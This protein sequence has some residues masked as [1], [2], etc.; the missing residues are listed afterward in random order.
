MGPPIHVRRADPGGV[1][2]LQPGAL[3]AI[4]TLGSVRREEAREQAADHRTPPHAPGR[5]RLRSPAS[6]QRS[7]V[8]PSPPTLPR[9]RQ[10]TRGARSA[11]ERSADGSRFARRTCPSRHSAFRLSRPRAPPLS[12]ARWLLSGPRSDGATAPR[13]VRTACP[14]DRRTPTAAGSAGCDSPAPARARCTRP[15]APR[16]TSA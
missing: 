15:S 16:R 5:W 9:T 1:S 10:G 2:S 14:S 4:S 11:R 3:W 6:G 12:S 7:W 13:S 8:R